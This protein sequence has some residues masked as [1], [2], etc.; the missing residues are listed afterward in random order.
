MPEKTISAQEFDADPS[1]AMGAAESSVVIIT[2]HGKAEY[3]L[4]NFADFC[5]L[6]GN[7]GTSNPSSP[8]GDA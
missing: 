7:D 6:S 4:L 3:V 2:E 8:A 1:A 5:K